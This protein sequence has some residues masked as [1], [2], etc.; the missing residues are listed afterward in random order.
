MSG[1]GL[2]YIHVMDVC[3]NAFILADYIDVSVII[4]IEVG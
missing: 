1:Y 3:M 2:G 4:V